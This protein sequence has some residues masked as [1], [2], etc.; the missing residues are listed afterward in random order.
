MQR[1]DLPEVGSKLDRA[2]LIVLVKL[3]LTEFQF[4]NTNQ[5]RDTGLSPGTNAQALNLLP[6]IKRLTNTNALRV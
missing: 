1:T 5:H 4:P 3:Q 2:G 6:D